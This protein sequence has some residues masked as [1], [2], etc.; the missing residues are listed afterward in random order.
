MTTRTTRHSV[1][2]I[3]PFTL[4]GVVG[5]QPAGTY[6]VET[7]EELVEGVSF[8]VYRR[9]ATTIFLPSAPGGTVSGQ[10]ATID[11]VELEAAQRRDAIGE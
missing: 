1:T 3:R 5:S 4:R 10:M 6:A 7:D 11:P 8:P 2:F 9:V